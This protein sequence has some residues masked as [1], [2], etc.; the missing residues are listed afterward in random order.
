MKYRRTKSAFAIIALAAGILILSGCDLFAAFG[1]RQVTLVNHEEVDAGSVGESGVQMNAEFYS[2]DG[3]DD[4][5][6]ILELDQDGNYE[7]RPQS[8]R[9][10]ISV[11]DI[12]GYSL[13]D[14]ENDNDFLRE[15]GDSPFILQNV[16]GGMTIKINISQTDLYDGTS[17]LIV[18]K[19]P[20]YATTN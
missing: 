10:Y 12:Y 14:D 7:F 15:D 17:G 13:L 11:Y 9:P 2:P 19:Q 5:F 18:R 8:G 20:S 1:Y 3:S 6:A 16:K 4:Y